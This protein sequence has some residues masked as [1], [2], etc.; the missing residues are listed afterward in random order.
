MKYYSLIE[1]GFGPQ[2]LNQINIKNVNIYLHIYIHL[3]KLIIFSRHCINIQRHRS[4]VLYRRLRLFLPISQITVWLFSVRESQWYSASGYI[5]KQG[6]VWQVR[7]FKIPALLPSEW[8]KLRLESGRIQNK[9]KL[10]KNK[11]TMLEFCNSW[12]TYIFQVVE[13]GISKSLL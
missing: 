8:G 1:Q 11:T 9:F 12:I 6:K 2:N 10:L 4:K 7:D 13:R 3:K 5:E